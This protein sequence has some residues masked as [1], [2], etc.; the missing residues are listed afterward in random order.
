MSDVINQLFADVPSERL[1]TFSCGHI[2]PSSNLKALVL[3]KGPR[4]G[5]LHFKFERR[6][7]QALVRGPYASCS[8][9]LIECELACRSGAK[10]SQFCQC[11]PRRDGCV[12]SVLQFLKYDQSRL[13]DDWCDGEASGEEK[14]TVPIGSRSALILDSNH[15]AGLTA[16]FGTAGQYACGSSSEG[17]RRTN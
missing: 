13:G 7:D 14:S 12:C 17:I 2:I 16:V 10:S 6:S 5:D 4:G 11:C 1:T 8:E 3:K 15:N 9:K